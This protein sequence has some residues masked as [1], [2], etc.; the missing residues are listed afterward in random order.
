MKKLFILTVFL[1]LA[2]CAIQQMNSKMDQSNALMSENLQ[3][4]EAS[5]ASIEA[6]TLEIRRSTQT[7]Q[8]VTWISPALLFVALIVAA[9]IY[10]KKFKSP[11]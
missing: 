2:S 3:T 1:G 9:Y 4:M 7:M 8:M 10:R 5:R 6:N 11:S